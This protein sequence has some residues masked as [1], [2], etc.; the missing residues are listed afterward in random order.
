[1]ICSTFPERLDA[2]YGGVRDCCDTIDVNA[3]WLFRD[4]VARNPEVS[5]KGGGSTGA[6]LGFLLSGIPSLL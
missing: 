3:L 2:V 4:L 5:V 6:T 1:M